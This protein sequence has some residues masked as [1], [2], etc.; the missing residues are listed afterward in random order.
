MSIK[1]ALRYHKGMAGEFL[2]AAQLHRLGLQAS[3]TYG[4]AKKTDVLAISTHFGAESRAL[5]IEVKT[6]HSGRWPVGNRVPEPSEKI[7][8]FVELPL[9][10]N[11]PPNF[12]VMSQREVYDALKDE[13]EKYFA[14]FQD[15]HGMDYGNRKGV[16]AMKKK[17]AVQHLNQWAKITSRFP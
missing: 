16:A 8:V 5:L 15:R 1:D 4:Q 6:S 9:D 7:W 13:E 12:Y 2:V 14:S 3:V 10:S 11:M 17:F